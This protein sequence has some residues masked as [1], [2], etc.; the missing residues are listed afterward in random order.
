MLDSSRPS[1]AG[2]HNF[3]HGALAPSGFWSETI[4]WIAGS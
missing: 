3:F 4:L 1:L 2:S